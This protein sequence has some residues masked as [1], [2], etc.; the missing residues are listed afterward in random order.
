MMTLIAF[1]TSGDICTGFQ[2]RA[3]IA[4]IERHYL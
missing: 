2:A 4:T 3:T 1:L